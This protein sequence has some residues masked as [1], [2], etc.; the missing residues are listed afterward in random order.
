[1]ATELW[2]V[3]DPQSIG[4]ELGRSSDLEQAAVVNAMADELRVACRDD[5]TLE[6]QTCYISDKLDAAGRRFITEL[7]AF[8]ALREESPS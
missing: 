3:T 4:K 5:R 1:M 8:V 7:A 6:M 2:R